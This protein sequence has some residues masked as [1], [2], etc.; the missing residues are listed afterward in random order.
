MMHVAAQGNSAYSLTYFRQEGL[1]INGRDTKNST[2][3]HHACSNGAETSLYYL[4]G[5]GCDIDA[6]DLKENTALHLCV[7]HSLSFQELRSIKEMLIRGANKEARNVDGLRPID[8]SHRLIEDPHIGYDAEALERRQQAIVDVLTIKKSFFSC[9][10]VKRPLEKV[11][12]SR[13]S[14]FLYLGMM[15]STYIML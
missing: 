15:F 7:M 12:P 3:L 10:Q 13:K 5:W 2:P 4:L 11:L 9:C 1:S 8:Y 6:Q 14:F